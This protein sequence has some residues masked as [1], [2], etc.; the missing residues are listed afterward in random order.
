VPGELKPTRIS[1]Q[2]ADQSVKLPIRIVKD[3]PIQ[4]DKYFIPK[5]FVI[6]GMEE[7]TQTPLL[8]GRPFLNTARA[9]FFHNEMI[10][11]KI[12]EEKITFHVNRVMKYPSNDNSIFRVEII[13]VLINEELQNDANEMSLENIF[14]N[15][16][17]T[18]EIELQKNPYGQQKRQLENPTSK[19]I[20]QG[21]L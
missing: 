10:F 3:M 7:D 8:L 9:I 21:F 20:C 12:S 16:N 18:I 15:L 4:I 14:E 11:F 19:A 5:D 6:V 1:L 17:L 13:D 2:L